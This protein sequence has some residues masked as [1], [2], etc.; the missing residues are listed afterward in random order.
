MDRLSLTLTS[1]RTEIVL[2]ISAVVLAAVM[3][4][5]GRFAC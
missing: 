2:Q 5:L 4:A 1:H 3:F